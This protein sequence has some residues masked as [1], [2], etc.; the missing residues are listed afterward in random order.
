[1]HLTAVCFFISEIS[2]VLI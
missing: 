1:L 2:V